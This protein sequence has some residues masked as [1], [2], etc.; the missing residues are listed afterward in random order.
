MENS[1]RLKPLLSLTWLASLYLAGAVLWGLFFNWGVFPMGFHDWANISAPRLTFLKEAITQGKLPLHTSDEASLG[2]VTDRFLSIPDQILSP[3]ILFLRV[4]SVSRFAFLNVVLLYSIGFLGLLWLQRKFSLTGVPFLILFALFNFNG[5]IL[6]HL[7]VGHATW[8]GYFLFP[9]FATLV[10]RLVEGER[11][12]GWIAKMAILLFSMF[13]QGSF[14]QFVW[15]LLFLALLA[16][17]RRDYFLTVI[18]GAGFAILLSLVRILPPAM[19]AGRFDVAFYG[20][21]PSLARLWEALITVYPPATRAAAQGMP[22]ALGYWEFSLY[23]GLAGAGFLLFF[24]VWRWLRRT[25]SEQAFHELFLPIT[26]LVALSIGLVYGIVRLIPIPLLAGE[27]V[28]SR[29]ISLPF[30]F[31]LILA[32]IE[33][34]RW[35]DKP[36]A[37]IWLVRI[38]CWALL[39]V[40]LHDLWLNF[41]VWT[42]SNVAS[43]YTLVHYESGH[44][45]N[46]P[47]P[48][49]YTVIG[50]GAALSSIS[51]GVL[52]FFVW[53]EGRFRFPTFSDK[54]MATNS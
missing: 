53:R 25:E 19:L 12:W 35:L 5:H 34:Q 49:Y 54:R 18:G 6:A 27:R 47:D 46:H 21:Y 31:I 36:H 38:P 45:V 23:I 50:L 39:L 51:L 40:G 44:V 43:L 48:A 11:G 29:M 2:G 52:I 14:H 17:V 28:S 20:G 10:F 13:L 4:M 24:G 9:W 22:V 16:I 26:G 8:G 7:S 33:F 37:N 42:V 32:V 1:A 41:N 3:Q 15:A 30:I